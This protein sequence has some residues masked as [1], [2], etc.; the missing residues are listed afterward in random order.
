MVPSGDCISSSEFKR[1][2]KMIWKK[3]DTDT[4]QDRWVKNF[5]FNEMKTVMVDIDL[6]EEIS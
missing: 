4:E 5:N 1:T 6:G 3:S 2:R